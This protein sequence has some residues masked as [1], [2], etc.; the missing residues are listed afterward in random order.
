MVCGRCEMAVK[1]ILEEMEIPIL[2]IKLGEV[3]TGRDFEQN[4]KHQFSEKLLNLGFELL[5]D[6]NSKTIERIKNLIIDLIYYQNQ[7]LKINL[8]A[9]L[10]SEINQDYSALSTLFSSTEGVTI[11]HYF[12]AQKIERVKELLFY[13]DMTLSEIAFL[14][15]YSTV[16]HL[17][18]Q[19]KKVTGISP[20]NFKKMKQIKRKPIDRL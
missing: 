7:K 8:S 15:D 4:E 10:T 18:N 5:D 2:S 13:N 12:I 16:S 14:L 19:F 20:S 9:Y 17:S 3:T 1:T 11:E 6:K